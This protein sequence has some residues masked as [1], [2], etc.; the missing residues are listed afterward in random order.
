MGGESEVWSYQIAQSIMDRGFVMFVPELVEI[1]DIPS[2]DCITR[3]KVGVLLDALAARG[4]TPE[5]PAL[6]LG[7]VTILAEVWRRQPPRCEHASTIR[8]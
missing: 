3:K 4:R 6:G 7:R 5:P 8:S 2:V 1:S